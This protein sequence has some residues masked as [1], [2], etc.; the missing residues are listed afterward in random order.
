VTKSPPDLG[1]L[2][3]VSTPSRKSPALKAAQVLGGTPFI[4]VVIA[5]V[6]VTGSAIT[7][8]TSP[9]WGKVTT[10]A[11]ARNVGVVPTQY[12]KP[13]VRTVVV[14]YMSPNRIEIPKINAVA[15]VF[16]EPTGADRELT[17]P[18]NPKQV[19]WWSG[20]APPGAPTGTAVFAG[21]INYAGVQGTLAR[22]GTLNPGDMIYV[23][24]FLHGKTTKLSFKVSAVRTYR[25]TNLPFAQ[26]FDQ[27]VA[28]R[29]AVVTCGGPFDAQT[30]NY[31]DN[32]VVYAV[33]A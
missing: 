19:G 29:I 6:L 1:Y 15:P 2:G 32:I 20:G 23:Y 11:P 22:I 5:I 8:V 24:G 3:G 30:G 16:A 4:L 18:L 13:I 12:A 33:P 28:E 27:N 9:N 14:T 25:K 21:H 31:L 17:I 7:W 26:I 10:A